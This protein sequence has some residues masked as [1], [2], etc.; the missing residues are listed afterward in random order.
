MKT[1]DIK[2]MFN[3]ELLHLMDNVN[4]E[5]SKQLVG[6]KVK[7]YAIND[8]ESWGFVELTVDDIYWNYDG[9]PV[10]SFGPDTLG[11]VIYDENRKRY[12]IDM[13]V[14]IELLD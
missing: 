4:K 11:P 8:F 6:K 1:F 3:R 5:I 13:S 9:S 10:S 2:N 7:V 12:T 14:G